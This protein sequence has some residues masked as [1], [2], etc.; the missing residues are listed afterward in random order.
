MIAL[1]ENKVKPIGDTVKIEIDNPLKI[2]DLK[3]EA[4]TVYRGE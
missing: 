2:K 3:L 4:G 1:S